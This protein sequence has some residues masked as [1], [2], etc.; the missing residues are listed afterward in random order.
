MRKKQKKTF[1]LVKMQLAEAPGL[2]LPNWA[3]NS[4]VE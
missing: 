1:E 2:T 4:T 3:E